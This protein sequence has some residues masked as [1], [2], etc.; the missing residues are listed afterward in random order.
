MYMV[1]RATFPATGCL[2]TAIRLA[3]SLTKPSLAD[4]GRPDQSLP[5]SIRCLLDNSTTSP[6]SES[7]QQ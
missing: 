3:Q 2:E 7:I 5:F 4:D 6:H 1:E